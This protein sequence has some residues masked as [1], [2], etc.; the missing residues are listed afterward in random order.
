MREGDH[1]NPEKESP[2]EMPV[3]SDQDFEDYLDIE[4][5]SLKED[6]TPTGM[7]PSPEI[8]DSLKSRK[9][10]RRSLIFVVLLCF[11]L[12][13]AI[14]LV[15]FMMRPEVKKPQIVAKRLTRSIPP[16][17]KQQEEQ[18]A[19]GPIGREGEEAKVLPGG[20]QE[21]GK[22]SVSK[23]SEPSLVGRERQA[24]KKIVVIEGTEPSA[25]KEGE[26]TIKAEGEEPE[27][28]ADRKEAEEVKPMVAKA[29][30]PKVQAV[31]EEKLPTDRFTINVASFRE[32]KRAERLVDELKEKGY[33]AFVGKATIPK[34][35][36]WYRVSVGRFSTRKEA[37]DFARTVKEKEGMDS[38][39]REIREAEK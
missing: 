24:A 14:L 15:F 10:S 1:E 9:R 3:F 13:M 34:K 21:E 2:E 26:R 17:G 19:P 7:D 18:R 28:K 38:F 20:V 31:P 16:A 36:T 27:K 30:E 37:Q 33:G 6:E 22:P 8:H 39:V 12:G 25:E 11:G 23:P 29:E 4:G 5:E 35:G 32:R